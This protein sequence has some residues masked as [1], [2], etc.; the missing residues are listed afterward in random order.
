MVVLDT[1]VI[2]KWFIE[3]KGS[4]RALLWLE[5]HIKKEEI[6]LL[7]ILLLLYSF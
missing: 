3:E 2:V 7:L 4:E 1:S 5:K 6:I